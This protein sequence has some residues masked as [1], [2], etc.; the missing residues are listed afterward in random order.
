[1]NNETLLKLCE[2]VKKH[3]RID[4]ADNEKFAVKSGLRNPDGTGVMAG[5]TKICSV[6]GYSFED[7]ERV[8]RP[9]KLIYRGIDMRSIITGCIK[10][11]RY[12]FEE[13][14]WLLLMGSLPTKSQ[15]DGFLDTLTEART[16]PDN[17]VEDMILKAPSPNVMN[18]MAR[19][20]LALY[21]Y[22]D[23]PEDT[24][25]PNVLRQSIQLIARLPAIMVYAYQAKRRHYDNKGMY[26]SQTKTTKSTAKA[27]LT[28]LRPSGEVSEAEA[29]LLDL[30]LIM[31]AEHG[32]GNNSTF[33]TRVLT[34]SG[35]DS[36]SAIS[37]GFGSL[38]GP[39]HGGANIKVEE[40]MQ[41]LRS[42]VKDPAA[43]G[44]VLDAL[45]K[46]LRREVMDKSGLIYG[47]GHAVYTVSDPRAEVITE[48]I[49]NFPRIGEEEFARDFALLQSVERLTPQAFKEVKGKRRKVCANVDLYSG[50]VYKM[51]GIPDDLYTPLFAVAR[52]PG[53]AAHRI[54]EL[55]TCGRI[56]RPA[57]KSVA[58]RHSY[59]SVDERSVIDEPMEYIPA[60]ER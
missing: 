37:A 50:L 29:R 9:G 24:S 22:D 36:Y 42:A 51:L 20:V 23:N 49:K 60:E 59:V 34:S 4:P 10:D 12:G 17:F 39:K 53:W 16:L 45:C 46:M 43:D 15:L 32:G 1:M 19:S 7:G 30:M 18:K 31:H 56:I 57:Y 3:N 8:P 35:T 55:L 52:T 48:Q 33:A 44:Q 6:D 38:K 5:L 2:E 13:V 40:M 21:S 11:G 14:I 26:I 25:L 54:E 27:I 47:M 58:N 28:S 41:Y